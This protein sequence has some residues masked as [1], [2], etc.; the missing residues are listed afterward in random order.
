MPWLILVALAVIALVMHFVIRAV[1]RAPLQCP[2]CGRL[3]RDFL[4]CEH[5]R[6]DIAAESAKWQRA[7]HS[8]YDGDPESGDP[9]IT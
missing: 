3:T 9:W 5:C 8:H 6:L 7:Y 2:G 4:F 1:D